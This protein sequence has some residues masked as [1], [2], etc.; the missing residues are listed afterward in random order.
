MRI[1]SKYSEGSVRETE[2]A[3]NQAPRNAATVVLPMRLC[4]GVIRY[5][6][7]YAALHGHLWREGLRWGAFCDIEGKQAQRHAPAGADDEEGH[8]GVRAD[9]AVGGSDV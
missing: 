6:I 1:V 9:P 3:E 4:P 5:S 2:I 8:G 7:C